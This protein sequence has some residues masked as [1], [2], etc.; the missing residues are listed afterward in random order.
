M[1][2]YRSRI[3]LHIFLCVCLRWYHGKYTRWQRKCQFDHNNVPFHAVQ[4]KRFSYLTY[5]AVAWVTDTVTAILPPQPIQSART[6]ISLLPGKTPW[7]SIT[8]KTGAELF[9]NVYLVD[10]RDARTR[11]LPIN[12]V[13]CGLPQ[14]HTSD[15]NIHPFDARAYA[16][17]TNRNTNRSYTPLTHTIYIQ[18]PLQQN[19]EPRTAKCLINANFIKVSLF[20]MLFFFLIKTG[21][22]WCEIVYPWKV[23]RTAHI[24][25]A[26]IRHCKWATPSD[27]GVFSCLPRPLTDHSIIPDF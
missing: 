24:H 5:A 25:L 10:G 11:T 27:A 17:H 12:G 15:Q 18:Q 1:L 19:V 21:R 6:A 13:G 2:I 8:C 22:W 14:L 23:I 16:S 9:N 3:H 20:C 7:A 4:S 26:C